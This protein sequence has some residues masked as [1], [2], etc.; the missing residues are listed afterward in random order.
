MYL[1]LYIYIYTHAHIYIYI[2]HIIYIYIHI[3]Y[4]YIYTYICRSVYHDR[5]RV[6]EGETSGKKEGRARCRTQRCM[7]ETYGIAVM[8]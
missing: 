5:S 2:Y 6:L 4:I 7:H 3:S 8:T 1:S